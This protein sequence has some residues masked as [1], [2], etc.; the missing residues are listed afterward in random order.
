MYT[1]EPIEKEAK[2]CMCGE[3]IIRHN[4]VLIATKNIRFDEYKHAENKMLFA[5]GK[6][7]L[8]NMNSFVS[9]Q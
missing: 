4:N 5:L 9:L 2:C 7:F 8:V 6:I 1:M 3:N